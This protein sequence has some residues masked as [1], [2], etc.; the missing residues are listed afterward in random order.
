MAARRIGVDER[1]GRLARRHRLAAGSRATGPVQ[2][3]SSTVGLH[4]TDPS[5]VYL[6]AGARMP[7]AEPATIERAL[8]ED[9]QLV[10]ILGMRRTMFVVP[11]DLAPVVQA[12]CTRAIAVQE[13]RRTI[14]LL[15]R[16][17]VAEDPAAW[18]AELEEAT[19]QVLAT[20]GAGTAAELSVHEPRLRTQLLLAEGKSYAASQSVSTRVLAQL[21]A[22]GRIIRGRPR[23]SW[24]SSQYRW[25][26]IEAWLEEGMDDLPTD[27]ARVELVRRWLAAF[28]P[29]TPADLKWWT[30]WTAGEVKGAVEKLGA[31]EVDLDGATGLVLPD[32]LEPEP[33]VEPW[34]ALLPALD[35]TVMGWARRDW[36]LGEHGKVLF[37]RNGNAGPTIWWAGRIVGGWAHRK[38]GEIAYRLLEDVGAEAAGAVTAAADRLRAWIGDVR[39]TPRFRTPL[40]R[41][42]ST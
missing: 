2:A 18:L 21:A 10:R 4:G 13:R 42:L 9:R 16:C 39:I 17:G 30:G 1:R 27:T 23:G 24:T 7:S 35:P 33:P 6:A 41:E 19:V 29:G 14:Q 15:T 40:E 20:H 3:A 25:T 11:L 8:Y 12:A 38:D 28:G 26:P 22:E 37:D 5:S 31:V 34:V 32:D 36:Y